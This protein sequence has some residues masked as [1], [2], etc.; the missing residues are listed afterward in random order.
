[1]G[2]PIAL[3]VPEPNTWR[4]VLHALDENSATLPVKG[5]RVAVQEYGIP[6]TGLIGGLAERGATVTPVPV[7]QWT[8]PDDLSPLRSAIKTVVKGKID[9]AIFTSSAQVRHLFQVAEVMGV[10][11]DLQEAFEKVMV[12]SIGPITSEELRAHRVAPTMEPE[13]PKMG[14]LVKEAADK[15]NLMLAGLRAKAH[16]IE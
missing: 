6:N 3:R 13:H 2:V 1:M 9:V 8:L 7:Y 16:S 15:A 5:R 10:Q 12:V 14:M 11:N 4:E